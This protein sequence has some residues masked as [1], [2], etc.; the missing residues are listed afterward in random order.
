M[1]KKCLWIN[2]SV[3]VFFVLLFFCAQR[4]Q[5]QAGL[6]VSVP[7]AGDTVVSRRQLTL[8]F[9]G[10]LMQHLPQVLAAT[11]RHGKV[12]YASCFAYVKPY[13][14][15]ADY[16][17][18]NLE[19]TLGDPPYS[20][21]PQF[22]SP[23]AL[24]WNMRQA[25]IDIA[26]MANNHVCDRG[27]EGILSTVGAL[28]RAGVP[29]TG[30]FTDSA[31][32]GRSHP[33]F[34]RKNGFRIALLNYTY[35]TNGLPVPAGRL[36]NRIDTVR[37][38]QDIRRIK[39]T[40]VTNIIVFLHWGNEYETLPNRDQRA[41]AELCHR[42]GADLVIGSHPHVVQPAETVTDAQGRV[43]GVT[44]FS[45]GNFVSNQRQTDTDG[46]I[47][48]RIR[49]T[50]RENAPMEYEPEY[51]IHW[52]YITADRNSLSGK[53]YAVVPSYCA[54]TV[55]RFSRPALDRFVARTRAR[56]EKYGRGFREI[57]E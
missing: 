45:M 37:I 14:G 53:R 31:D 34:I 42:A 3:V 39:E 46:G 40:D 25:G 27:S 2:G 50:S 16:V 8:I 55:D 51:L 17:I 6:P 57:T 9:T 33:L 15:T 29:H 49:L 23:R 20:G 5:R 18:A 26:V 47:S 22:R 10:D 54:D 41:V 24:A 30:A 35:G 44:V 32:F 12:D 52:T 11:D 21:Y 13:F 43:C 7:E 38:A 1:S 36:V 48:V 56:M 19:T 4:G 28:D